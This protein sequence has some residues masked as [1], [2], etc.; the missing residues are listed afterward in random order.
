MMLDIR[1]IL[2]AVLMAAG[3]AGCDGPDP[4]PEQIDAICNKPSPPVLFCAGRD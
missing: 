3:L 1:A 2:V 4:T